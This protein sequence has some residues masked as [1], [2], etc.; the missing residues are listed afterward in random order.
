MAV[1]PDKAVDKIAFY[2]NH[3]TPWSANAVAI[4]TTTSAVSALATQTTAAR[5]AYNAQQEAQNT[6]KAAT[7]ALK[8]AVNAMGQSGSDIIKSIKT[9]AATA[10]DSVYTLAQIPAPATPSPV[11]P[12]GT[13]SN[14]KVALN[15]NGSLK[16]T[17]KCAN[18][19]GSVGTIY[20]VYRRVA[21]DDAFTYLGGVGTKS[22]TDNTLPAGASAVTY[23]IQAVRSTAVGAWAQ[24]NVNFG[25]SGGT[26][27][28]T[29]FV[30]E[31]APPP[32]AKLAA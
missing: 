6:A 12:P 24:F 20:Q 11:A 1:V 22:I 9:K 13:P 3:D 16:L 32:Q 10:G 17:W 23:Q 29:A 31:S 2:E 25:V 8:S 14:F 7:L 15:G 28:M 27:A 19:A 21:A 18:P 5:A 30:T 26:G 4:G